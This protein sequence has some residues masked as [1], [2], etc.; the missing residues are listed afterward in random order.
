MKKSLFALAAVGAFAGA[1]QAQSSVTV[2]GILDVGYVGGNAKASTVNSSANQVNVAETVSL[3]GQ[4][5]QTTSRL[6]FRGTEDLGGGTT[7]FFTFETG[8]QP[9]QSSLSPFNNRQAFIGLGQKGMGNAR[10]GTQYTPIHE[11]VGATGAN[12]LNNLVGDVI[13]PQNTGLTNQDGSASNA[14]AGYTV[15]A[16]NMIRFESESFSGFK[17]K[18]F[19]V[20]NS[21]DENQTTY[22]GTA[23][24]TATA[25]YTNGVGYTGGNT[26]STGWGLGLDFA[27]QKFLISA[28]YQSFKQENAWTEQTNAVAIGA[29]NGGAATTV[30]QNVQSGVLTNLNDNQWYVGATYDFGI[31]KAY[32]QYINRKIE[33]GL[34]SNAYAKRTAQ[35]IGLRGNVTKTVEL[36]GSAGMGRT[37][38]FGVSNPTAN[39]T[40]Y[41]IGSNYWLSKRTNLYAIFG[42]SNTSSTSGNY[43]IRATDANAY[44]PRNLSANANNYAVGVRHTF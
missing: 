6:G 37:S 5:A 22:R 17:G 42:A 20:Q 13:Y 36:W 15:R 27:I 23:A 39:F 14:N 18:A 35:Q 11:A 26:N 41:Q 16:N 3:L 33:S 43:V 25:N 4:S 29:N 10:I 38:A 19:Y 34:D 12:Q 2:Y 28:N 9:N 7:A 1:A 40:G 44:G 32:A 8:L 30:T 21:R 24:T 31:V